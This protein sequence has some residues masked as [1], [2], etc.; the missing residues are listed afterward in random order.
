ME[1]NLG[2]R[3]FE[4]W[5]YLIPG[6]TGICSNCFRSSASLMGPQYFHSFRTVLPGICAPLCQLPNWQKQR[7]SPAR[8]T[9]DAKAGLD[10]EA[11]AFFP[12]PPS[13]D[14][15]DL[16]LGHPP[17]SPPPEVSLGH[18][19]AIQAWRSLCSLS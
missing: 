15:N 19:T 18:P 4:S 17:P 3:K 1:D 14:K 6:F 16:T 13:P 9:L 8:K 2:M 5:C 7:Y 12:L 10:S 11:E